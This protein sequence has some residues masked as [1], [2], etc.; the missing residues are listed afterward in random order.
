MGKKTKEKQRLGENGEVI[1][2]E[3]AKNLNNTLLHI[4]DSRT[5]SKSTLNNLRHLPKFKLELI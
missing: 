2:V 1:K 4:A 5:L 3:N